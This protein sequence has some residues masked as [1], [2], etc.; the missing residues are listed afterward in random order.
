MKPAASASFAAVAALALA[1][2]DAPKPRNPP[3]AE[4]APP[5]APAADA[6]A[7]AATAAPAAAAS[8]GLPKR[9]GMAGF[10]VDYVG[11]AHDPLNRQPAVVAAGK[12]IAVSG[13]AF[14]ST[15]K[16]PAQA[17][18]VVI[19]GVAHGAAYGSPRED[20]AKFH[21]NDALVNVGY[22]VTLPAGT[23]PAG[24]HTLV[25]RVVST[26]GGG[27]QESVPVKF[28]VR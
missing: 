9:E 28:T 1:A 3:P 24:D 5:V 6:A 14:D 27:Y 13:F 16:Q 19:D 10:Y 8:A 2:C 22:A 18:D 11:D 20:V 4:A 21:K 7:P 17:V 26:D 23:V 12:P 25:L 15:S